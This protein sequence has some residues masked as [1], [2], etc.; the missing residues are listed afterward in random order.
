MFD[1]DTLIVTYD[2]ERGEPRGGR[3]K[4]VDPKAAGLGDCTDCT[5]CVQVCPTGIDIRKGLQYECI[6]CASCVDACDAVMDRM[7]YARGLVR[8]A[9]QHSLEHRTTHVVRPRIIVYGALLALLTA[10]LFVA[11]ALRKPVGL[12]V[13]H[14]RNSLY[15]LL[16]TGEAE[17]VYTLKIINKSERGHRFRVSVSGPGALK[18]DPPDA[19]FAVPAGEVYNAAVRV[20]SP[21]WSDDDGRRE[22]D[23]GEAEDSAARTIEFRIV[24]EDDARLAARSEARF[25]VPEQ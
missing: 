23:D 15:R 6:A 19:T 18:L 25:F 2:A 20:R 22:A 9:T 11:L 5:L 24:A 16:D 12:D 21:A 17:N 13:L 10:G 7:G 1:R 4:G 14:D 3:K 8:Y